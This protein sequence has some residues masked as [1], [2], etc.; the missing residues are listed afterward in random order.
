GLIMIVGIIA[1]NSI[2][3]GYQYFKELTKYDKDTAVKKA[4]GLRLRPN[5]MTALSA[6]LALI[7]LAAAIGIGAEMQQ[8]LAIAVIG[9]FIVAMPLLLIVLPSFIT[10]IHN[11]YK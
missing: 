8:A 9:G 11:K 3:T 6:I 5:L 10:L 7:P 2:F 1:E 4:I